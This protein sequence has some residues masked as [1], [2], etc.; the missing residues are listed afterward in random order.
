MHLNWQ[1]IL[2]RG[3]WWGE[4]H[5]S[6]RCVWFWVGESLVLCVEGCPLVAHSAVL[7]F[8]FQQRHRRIGTIGLDIPLS[9]ADLHPFVFYHFSLSLHLFQSSNRLSHAR[10]V[11]VSLLSQCLYSSIYLFACDSC[12]RVWN[13]YA[14][15]CDKISLFQGKNETHFWESHECEST[16]RMNGLNGHQSATL[17]TTSKYASLSTMWIPAIILLDASKSPPIITKP[18][19]FS[20]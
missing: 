13:A 3:S 6:S 5:C 8:N 19:K 1:F 16:K 4:R 14:R 7:F 17:T 15:N 10:S 12:T 9:T 18:P 11:C 20:K 2:M